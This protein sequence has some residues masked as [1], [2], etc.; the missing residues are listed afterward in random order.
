MRS[1]AHQR[2]FVLYYWFLAGCRLP[3]PSKSQRLDQSTAL[4]G[5]LRGLVQPS[6]RRFPARVVIIALGEPCV[7]SCELL[8]REPG[9]EW[10][11]VRA[12]W[13]DTQG[14]PRMCGAS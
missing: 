13:M 4:P 1:G 5:L 10:V 2:D 8:W 3:S 7:C 11:A 12:A 9:E 14:D 6:E